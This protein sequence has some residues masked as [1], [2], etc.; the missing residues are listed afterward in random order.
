MNIDI[1]NEDCLEGMKR[2]PD[3]SIDLIVTDPPFFSGMTSSGYKRRL[4]D[5]S[6]TVPFWK[7]LFG[8]WQRVLKD[9]AQIYLHT[10]WRTYPFMFNLLDEFFILRNLIVWDYGWLKAGSF[11]RFRH[12]LIIFA[13]HGKSKR[14]FENCN[15]NCD[16]WNIKCINYTLPTKHH[17]A[18]KPV[19]LCEKMIRNSSNEGDT[20]LDC[21]AGS[22]T[23]GV[24]CVKLNRNFVGFELDER[25]FKVAERRIVEAQNLREQ[26]LFKEAGA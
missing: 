17:Q 21:F 23:T 6:L 14:T 12:E 22:G 9:G 24:A 20:V 15:D 13:T 3:G 4:S 16:V 25:F 11:Y 5:N 8:E 26:N 10:D 18:E 7:I 1:Y 19:E 2:L